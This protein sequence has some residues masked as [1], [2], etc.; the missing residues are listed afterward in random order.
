MI[1][2]KRTSWYGWTYLF[3]HL[4]P[5]AGSVLPKTL[6]PMLIAALL[7]GFAASPSG[8]ASLTEYD[9]ARQLF[10]ETYGMQV[11]GIVFGFMCIA[12]LNI[13]YSRYWEGVGHVK[14]MHS[15][16]SDAAAQ[17]V[18]FDRVGCHD[19]EIATEPFCR[20]LIHLFSQLSAMATMSLHV[21]K[22]GLEATSSVNL[23]WL[24]AP[25]GSAGESA[26]KDS[27]DSDN[28]SFA[29]SPVSGTRD[30]KA[31]S[32]SLREMTSTKPMRRRRA[33]ALND[34]FTKEELDFYEKNRGCAVH[35]TVNRIIR[36]MSTRMAAGGMAFA[37][38]IVSRIYQE[39]SNGL[40]YTHEASNTRRSHWLALRAA[41]V[42]ASILWL[43]VWRVPQRVQSGD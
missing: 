29:K 5:G 25:A 11:F 42:R 41:A 27:E 13:C 20:H 3:Q 24:R 15:K 1:D 21:N 37:P 9:T 30:S 16:W 22:A 28:G 33:E 23:D 14:M 17:A 12:R 10:G 4:S 36:T 35:T 31:G 6:P 18:A 38:P 43:F 39:L 2:Y 26:L 8:P 32:S 40:L 19:T 34:T 7:G